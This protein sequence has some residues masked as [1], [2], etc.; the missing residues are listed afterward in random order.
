MFKF[1]YNE[2]KCYGIHTA[3]SMIRPILAGITV[4]ISQASSD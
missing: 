4:F 3:K 2:T 1:M